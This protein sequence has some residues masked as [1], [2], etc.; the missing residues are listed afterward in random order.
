M[1]NRKKQK[2]KR[3]IKR[4]AKQFEKHRVDAAWVTEIE[5]WHLN[6]C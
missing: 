1:A 6:Y 4:R 3:Y 2:I 5:E